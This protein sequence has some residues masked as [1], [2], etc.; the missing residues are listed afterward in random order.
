V[1]TVREGTDFGKPKGHSSRCIRCTAELCQTLLPM[2]ETHFYLHFIFSPLPGGG[3][4]D[5]CISALEDFVEK[6][7]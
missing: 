4:A 2:Q 3:G 6:E 7:G 1:K 5:K